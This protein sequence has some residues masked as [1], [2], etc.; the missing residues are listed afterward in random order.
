MTQQE[1]DLIADVLAWTTGATCMCDDTLI[2]AS[3]DHIRE[4][5]AECAADLAKHCEDRA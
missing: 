5:A 2:G 4:Q 1:L 3:H